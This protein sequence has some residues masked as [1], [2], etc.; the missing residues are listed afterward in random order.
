[1][2]DTL[3]KVY[4]V[5]VNFKHIF[6]KDTLD[7]IF[8]KDGIDRS[9]V[10]SPECLL[11]SQKGDYLI[12][13]LKKEYYSSIEDSYNK[14]I[15]NSDIINE[16]ANSINSEN[17]SKKT[18]KIIVWSMVSGLI[19]ASVFIVLNYFYWVAIPQKM[20]ISINNIFQDEI[21]IDR[22]G[23]FFGQ[24]HNIKSD[25]FILKKDYIKSKGNVFYKRVYGLEIQAQKDF[26]FSYINSGDVFGIIISSGKGVLDFQKG[27][28]NNWR[29]SLPDE[30]IIK[31]TGTRIFVDAAKDKTYIYLERGSAFIESDKIQVELKQGILYENK[32]AGWTESVSMSRSEKEKWINV[33]RESYISDNNFIEKDEAVNNKVNSAKNDNKGEKTTV[34]TTDDKVYTGTF[35]AVGDKLEIVTKDGKFII[36]AVNVK[37]ILRASE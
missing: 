6:F 37:K 3:H 11:N 1:M 32:D 28:C 33:F 7:K 13:Q 24:I 36:P 22:N 9:I 15:V 20:V 17:A 29:V 26:N 34:I 4:G 18:S 23:L 5:I 8:H 31:V 21:S 10:S 12:N 14:L 19:A 2:L 27:E 35:K 16:K 25:Y 30:S